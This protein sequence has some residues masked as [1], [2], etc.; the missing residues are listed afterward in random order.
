MLLR[1]PASFENYWCYAEKNPSRTVS[2]GQKEATK[3]RYR[4]AIICL[5]AA[6]VFI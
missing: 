1:N 6:F 5:K 2:S 4:E 3:A